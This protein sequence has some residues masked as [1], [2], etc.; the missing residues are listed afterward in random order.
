MGLFIN[1]VSCTGL[2]NTVTTSPSLIPL[3]ISTCVSV[4]KPKRHRHALGPG[5]S[6]P[7]HVGLTVLGLDGAEG[8][9]QGVTPLLDGKG[10]VDGHAGAQGQSVGSRRTVTGYS[11][12]PDCD[13]RRQRD[14]RHLPAQWL[15]GEG[16]H[17]NEYGHPHLNAGHIGFVQVDFC[18]QDGQITHRQLLA[19]RVWHTRP[20]ENSTSSPRHPSAR[21]GACFP[22]FDGPIPAAPFQVPVQ[23]TATA[24]RM[25]PLLTISSAACASCSA[26]LAS[27]PVGVD[28]DE[29]GIHLVINTV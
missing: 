15:T 8:N 24:G 9:Q 13:I 1:A 21:S 6:Y 27:F 12:T 16:I 10:N 4:I 2:A 7:R 11:T 17:R 19:R 5:G 23:P 18:L 25:V 3:R 26:T 20:P 28:K 22:P 14:L 29:F